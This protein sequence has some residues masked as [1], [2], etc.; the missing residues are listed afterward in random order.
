MATDSLEFTLSAK[1]SPNEKASGTAVSSK[2]KCL[3]AI[4]ALLHGERPKNIESDFALTKK[5]HLCAVNSSG[6]TVILDQ[7]L[8]SS[9]NNIF[10]KRKQK[11]SLLCTSFLLLKILLDENSVVRGSPFTP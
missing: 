3:C 2:A 11:M 6:K 8:C 5:L 1:Q 7:C 10:R 9:L 4:L